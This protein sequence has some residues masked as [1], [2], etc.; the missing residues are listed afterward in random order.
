MS[1]D[2][3]KQQ[4]LLPFKHGRHREVDVLTRFGMKHDEPLDFVH[5]PALANAEGAPTLKLL[6]RRATQRRTKCIEER[7]VAIDMRL[8]LIQT[9]FK[10]FVDVLPL[11]ALGIRGK[12]ERKVLDDCFFDEA[13][14]KLAAALGRFLYLEVFFKLG[15]L[16]AGEFVKRATI[17]SYHATAPAEIE[18]LY[19]T[20]V[21]I[22]SK[23]KQ[24][25][26]SLERGLALYLPLIL[27]ALRVCMETLYRNQYPLS[28]GMTAPTMQYILMAMD[29]KITQLLDPDEH[30]SHI[31][32]LETTCES[33][34]VKASHSYQA[35][36]RQSRLRDQY[37]QTSEALHTIFPN[38]V[39]GKSRKIL[40]L[41]GGAAIANYPAPSALGDDAGAA[42]QR[43]SSPR[44]GAHTSHVAT[45]ATRL[46]LL[47]VV[48]GRRDSSIDRDD[49]EDT[50]SD[51]V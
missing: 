24:R 7:C 40:K 42:N 8:D 15:C 39:S 34:K 20:V 38:P 26:E 31:G 37:F 22:F 13:L 29:E 12:R 36:K 11:S 3:M 50:R 4:Y 35:K 6:G 17:T 41:R 30:L 10:S 32:I 14:E 48:E 19:V 44:Q 23:I 21:R 5:I 28:F 9:V 49:D 46:R 16:G 43:S 25:M 1:F 27:L 51:P 2:D 18:A 45:V 33:S 47:H